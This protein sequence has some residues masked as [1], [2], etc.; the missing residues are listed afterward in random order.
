MNT[1]SS[2]SGLGQQTITNTI[3]KPLGSI[4]P[5]KPRDYFTYRQAQHTKIVHDA[6]I[7]FKCF[8]RSHNKQ[9]RLLYTTLAD[10]FCIT[11]VECLLRGTH[12]VLILYKTDT[13][14]L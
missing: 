14:S 13:F 10:W 5:L 1:D 3:K 8:V 9:R 6:H 11:E 4:N 2:G 7:V 12:R